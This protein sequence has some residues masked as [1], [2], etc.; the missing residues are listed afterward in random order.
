MLNQI[1]IIFRLFTLKFCRLKW[2]LTVFACIHMSVQHVTMSWLKKN[3]SKE[4]FQKCLEQWNNYV[5]LIKGFQ[6]QSIEC[7]HFDVCLNNQVPLNSLA[8]LKV[9]RLWLKCP[10]TSYFI[11]W[12]F[13]KEKKLISTGLIWVLYW[14]IKIILWDTFF[15]ILD[16]SPNYK[17][18]TCKCGEKYFGSF[19]SNLGLAKVTPNLLPV[20]K[21]LIN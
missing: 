9:D 7:I 20:V 13:E 19:E 18:I 12:I 10:Q 15:G 5:A 2:G 6:R 16:K 4:A 3:Y 8:T 14:V 17:S 21:L 1:E 11:P